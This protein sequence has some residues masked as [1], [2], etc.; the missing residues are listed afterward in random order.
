[1][2]RMQPEAEGYSDQV[3]CG[4]AARRLDVSALSELR[5]ELVMLV[6]FLIPGTPKDFLTYFAGLTKMRFA[7][8]VLIAT[9]GRIPSIV[10]STA[11]AS[12]AG[13][14]NWLLVGVVVAVSLLCVALG[15]LLYRRLRAKAS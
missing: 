10:T 13:S 3:S 11:A 15:G 9:F 12:A 2:M 4:G 6:I 7:P 5:N 1:M 14:G 8:V